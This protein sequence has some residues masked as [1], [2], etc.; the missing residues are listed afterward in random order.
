MVIVIVNQNNTKFYTHPLF[1]DVN[2][3]LLANGGC[4][5]NC[6]NTDGFFNCFCDDGYEKDIRDF[7][8]CNGSNYNMYNRMSIIIT[9]SCSTDINECELETHDCEQQCFNSIGSYN[10]GCNEGCELSDNENSCNG[11]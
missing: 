1:V 7:R 6:T 4:Q 9:V 2:E 11:N 3:C 8:K 5:Q 10:C